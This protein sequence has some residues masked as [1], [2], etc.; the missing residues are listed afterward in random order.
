MKLQELLKTADFDKMFEYIV[1]FDHKT[2][3]SRFGFQVAYELLCDMELP[4]K[5]DC[6]EIEVVP[7]PFKDDKEENKEFYAWCPDLEGCNWQGVI[8]DEVVYSP[9]LPSIPPNDM[10]AGLCLWHLTFYGFSPEEMHCHFDDMT[11]ESSEKEEPEY[12]FQI[13][14]EKT[15]QLRPDPV[16]LEK[17]EYK[18][19]AAIYDEAL[20]KE[21]ED[22]A[23]QGNK[24]G[25]FFLGDELLRGRKARVRDVKRAF[26]LIS[27]SANQGFLKARIA[28]ANLYE[29]GIGTDINL[30][31]AREQYKL[32]SESENGRGKPEEYLAMLE[33]REENFDEALHWFK[34]ALQKGN[35]GVCAYIWYLEKKRNMN[36]V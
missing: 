30:D 26:S 18:K 6:G 4:N 12:V 32:A 10:I 34:Q 35:K 17:S 21:L 2:A 19:Q 1:K 28:L 22:L 27:A 14:S 7:N 36:K 33:V 5:E 31:K 13:I 24:Y 29:Y 3:G 9:K 23:N 20:M 8:G 15:K 11:E 16:N 25:L